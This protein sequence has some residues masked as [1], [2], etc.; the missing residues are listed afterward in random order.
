MLKYGVPTEE[1][2]QTFVPSNDLDKPKSPNTTLPSLV[3]KIFPGL[4]SLCNILI[5]FSL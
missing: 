5:P 1:T 2:A 4:R 3:K